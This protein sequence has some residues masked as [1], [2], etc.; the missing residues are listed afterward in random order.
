MNFPVIVS[1]AE[2]FRAEWYLIVAAEKDLLLDFL[3]FREANFGHFNSVHHCYFCIVFCYVMKDAFLWQPHRSIGNFLDCAWIAQPS[4]QAFQS[5][6]NGTILIKEVR[7]FAI[8]KHKYKQR[9][10]DNRSDRT[11]ETTEWSPSYWVKQIAI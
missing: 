7:K 8:R 9:N 4:I 6:S 10:V 3:E 11:R 2:W 5:I 1:I